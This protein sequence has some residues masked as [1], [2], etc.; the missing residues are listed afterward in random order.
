MALHWESQDGRRKSYSFTEMRNLSARFAGFLKSQSIGPGDAVAGLVPRTPELLVTILG[1]WRAGAVYQPLFTAFGPKAIEHRLKTSA[2]KL[3]VTDPAN[4]P[5]LDDI[6]NAPRVAVVTRPDSKDEVRSGDFDFNE[7]LARQSTEFEPVLR[8]A[9]DLF[10]MMSTSGTTG[11]PKG[12]PVPL[13]ALLSFF[14]YMRDAV[15]SLPEDKFWNMADPGWAYGL[16]YAVT[17]PLLLGH[18]RHST[19]VLSRLSRPTGLSRAT[20]SAIWPALRP[21]IAF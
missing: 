15:G 11:L 17:G 16:Y 3:V 1:T 7:E 14:V 20:A 9:T 18:T 19:M 4:R 6:E 5:K 21:L 10:L 13:K 12:V 8:R 2:A